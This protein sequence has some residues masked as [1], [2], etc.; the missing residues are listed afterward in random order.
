MMSPDPESSGGWNSMGR[1][2]VWTAALNVNMPWLFFIME[3]IR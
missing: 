1:F 3:N 2:N